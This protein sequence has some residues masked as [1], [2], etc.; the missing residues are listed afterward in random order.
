[1]FV[2]ERKGA[3]R[4]R[5]VRPARPRL[6]GGPDRGPPV[7]ARVRRRG[8]RGRPRGQL[9]PARRGRRVPRP[10]PVRRDRADGRALVG[11]RPRPDRRL[12]RARARLPPR[13][14]TRPAYRCSASASVARPS[15]R[16][17]AVRSW[18]RREV[19][20]GWHRVDTDEPDL[21]EAG[22]WFQWHQDRWVAPEGA[23]VAGTYAARG[24]GVRRRPQPG[25][26]VPP[27]AHPV[28][29]GGLA[30][31][32]RSRLP[33]RPRV[34]SRRPARPDVA[35]RPPAPRS[36]RTGWSTGS[37]TRWRRRDVLATTGSPDPSS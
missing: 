19:E 26:P 2:S 21:V 4:A 27:R 10:H 15:R 18:R 22:P 12:G 17:W 23:R 13:T 7:R 36:A 11:L 20:I 29:A 31:Q 5:T 28:D 16:P 34:R 14:R 6:A 1:M 30:R 24:P 35:A 25:R 32:R 3:E 8:A 37:S 9:P 33:R